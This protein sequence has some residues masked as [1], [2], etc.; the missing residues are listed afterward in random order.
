MGAQVPAGARNGSI[1]LRPVSGVPGRG[2]RSGPHA[3]GRGGR[4]LGGPER[5]LRSRRSSADVARAFRAG[6][7]RAVA[8][9]ARALGDIDRAEDALQDAS[10]VALERWTRDGVP[11][12]RRLDHHDREAPRDRPAALRAIALARRSGRLRT[13]EEA[14][15]DSP[16]DEAGA[17]IPDERLG[18][19]FACCH[20]RWRGRRRSRSR[21]AWSAA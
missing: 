2:D 9:L 20:P 5:S 12:P 15:I 13:L 6:Y 4:A 14:V 18:L 7:G 19:M 3:G 10:A 16:F 21:C 17:L 8:I 11:R 1:E